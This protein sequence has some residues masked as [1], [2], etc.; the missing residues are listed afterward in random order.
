MRIV[1]GS[2]L[3]RGVIRTYEV[4]PRV[5]VIDR[6]HPAIWMFLSG[7]VFGAGLG[8]FVAVECIKLV[9]V[10]VITA[11]AACSPD[12]QDQPLDKLKSL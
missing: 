7:I 8:A 9:V 4:S 1:G 12:Q 10:P 11:L 3:E 5:A 2:K 6:R